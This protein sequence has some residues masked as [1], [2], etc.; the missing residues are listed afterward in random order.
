MKSKQSPDSRFVIKAME[1]AKEINRMDIRLKDATVDAKIVLWFASNP[2]QGKNIP[3]WRRLYSSEKY[4]K[5]VELLR[6]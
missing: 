3:L 5:N 2:A 1:K 6:R 4:P